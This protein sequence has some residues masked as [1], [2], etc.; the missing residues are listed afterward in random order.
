MTRA[1]GSN[2]AYRQSIEGCLKGAIGAHGLEASTLQNALDRLAPAIAGLRED[3]DLGRLPLLRIA[4]DTADLAEAESAL[5][6]LSENARTII[7]FGTGGSGLGGQT[8]AQVAGWNIP[9]GAK[10]YRRKRPR[11]RFYDNL[12]PLT[13]QGSL[14][15]MDLSELRFVVTS[16]SGG[17]TETLVQA[18]TAIEAVR[19]A[20]LGARIPELFLGITEPDTPGKSNGLRG[21]FRS[22]GIPM[23]EHHT[24]IGGRFSC[25]TNVGLV[26]AMARG[27]DAHAIRAGAREVVN[28][29]LSAKS[30][31]ESAPAI[32]AAAMVAL[33]KSRGIRTLVMMPYSDRLGRFAEWYVQLWA[34]SLGKGGEGTSPIPALGPLDQHSQLQLFMDGPREI[35]VTVLRVAGRGTGPVIDAD[36]AA[37]AGSAFLG[38][39]HVGD[40]VDAQAHAVTAAL[41][42]AGRPVRTIDVPVLD[43]RAI[44]ALLMHFM[45][46][47]ILAGRLIG[48]DPFDQPAVELAKVL[49][50]E[51]LSKP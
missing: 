18:I 15:G 14:D 50:K 20:G 37:A 21:L 28:E 12:D 46:E 11:T 38:G 30:P 48:V 43:E 31:A 1:A 29:L 49:T 23:L 19:A 24:G 6:R 2:S 51:R 27:L 32:G 36:M 42:R 5:D 13:V 33:A 40:V 41:A 26:P 8:L 25:L 45:L 35:A 10:V 39:K 17:T 4:E 22:L 3:Y 7:F 44:G 47:T 9:G 16:K 34:E